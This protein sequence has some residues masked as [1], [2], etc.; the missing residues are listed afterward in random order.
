M[1]DVQVDRTWCVSVRTKVLGPTNTRGARIRVWRGDT[2]YAGDQFGIT[3]PCDQVSA[4][5]HVD[6]V[7]QYLSA[8]DDSWDG[9]WV[10]AWLDDGMVA[11]R[12]GGV[13]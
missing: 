11:V 6:A 5:P 2:T 1:A 8:V 9:R 10:V 7:A 4:E 12:A 3:I 13:S